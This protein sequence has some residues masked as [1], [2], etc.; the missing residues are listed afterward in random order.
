MPLLTRFRQTAL[1]LA[2]GWISTA[3]LAQDRAP[4]EPVTSL[5]APLLYQLLIGELELQRGEL[6]TAYQLLLDGAR[7]TGDEGL[8]RR[9]VSIALQARAGSEALTAVKAWRA[10]L[11]D[12]QEARQTQVQL[13]AALTQWGE[14]IEPWMAWMDA[15]PLAQQRAAL[16]SLPRLLRARAGD[17]LD[18]LG[19]SLTALRDDEAETPWR[20]SLAASTLAQLALMAGN[21]PLATNQLHDA[22]RDAPQNALP[23][24]QA[25]ELMRHQ[26]SVENLVL[27]G[28]DD[29]ELRLAYARGLARDS[30]T[31]EALPQF[32]RLA[33]LQPQ[34]ATHHY[35]VASL[36]LDLK[37]P[38]DALAA[39]DRY[40]QRLSK[41]D[42]HARI[43]AHLLRAQA[44][45]QLGRTSDATLAL[46][47]AEAADDG[48][49]QAD[50]AYRRASLDLRAGRLPAARARIQA[51]PARDDAG[52]ER[53]LLLETQLLREAGDWRTAHALL[54]RMLEGQGSEPSAALLYEQAMTA[55][56]L[57]QHELMERQLRALIDRDPKHAHA[58]NAL[59]YSL[60]DRNQRLDEA[61]TLIERAIELGGHEPF[62]I[63]SLGWVAY[64]EGHLDDAERLLRQ[65]W[66]GRPD[67]EIVA[68]LAEVLWHRGQRDEA[69]ALLTQAAQREPKHPA[70]QALRKK[71]GLR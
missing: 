7:R 21:T 19:P 13:H 42:G 51:L 59:G 52:V 3:A 56:H 1:A 35:A 48:S 64:R 33:E 47:A 68:H 41:E 6:S 54:T 60:A 71:L 58:Y 10:A 65:A 39:A 31:A 24:W 46:D 62:L 30:R 61:R 69:Q 53:R 29:A 20:R 16:E 34:Q 70:L 2:M 44:L 50:I 25:V 32:Q 40:L 49:R 17:G 67:A 57:G 36:S 5:D 43:A 22:L 55:E 63:D 45:E 28:L 23:R 14:M 18:L 15:A 4:T 11:P 8:F 66:R 12:S 37:Q 9:C 38:S 26:P 27:E